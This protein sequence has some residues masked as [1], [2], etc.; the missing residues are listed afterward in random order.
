MSAQDRLR[1]TM[2]QHTPLGD[3]ETRKRL[4]EFIE[5]L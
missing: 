1:A 3:R 2:L 5:T 4:V